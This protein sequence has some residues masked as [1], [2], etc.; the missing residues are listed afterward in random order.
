[1][2]MKKVLLCNARELKEGEIRI[3]TTNGL[4]IAV[5]KKEG[6]FFAFADTCT[7]AECS[8]GEGELDGFEIICPCHG[9]RFDIQT[10]KAVALPAV[11]DVATY[12]VSE[13]GGKLFVLLDTPEK[14]A[15]RQ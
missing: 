13:E 3:F 11:T 12:H 9:A 10:G 6:S 15:G 4:R 14:K 5:A 7:H 8:L 2:R 1:M